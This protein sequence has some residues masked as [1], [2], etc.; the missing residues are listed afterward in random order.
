M[1][2]NTASTIATTISTSTS[3]MEKKLTSI[4]ASG[5]DE[6]LQ[7]SPPKTMTI[8]EALEWI[9]RDELVDLTPDAVPWRK[10]VLLGNERPRRE[11]TV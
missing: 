3:P 6:N 10:R 9:D 1:T 8:D 4:R 7:L 5:K 2:D 11:S